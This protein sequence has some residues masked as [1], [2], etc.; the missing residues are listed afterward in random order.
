VHLLLVAIEIDVVS[1]RPLGHT[2]AHARIWC[3]ALKQRLLTA[4]MSIGKKNEC[5]G[6]PE[7]IYLL[8]QFH[9]LGQTL[10]MPIVRS[11]KKKTDI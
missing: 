11:T 4:H 10:K 1:M 8:V 5:T 7:E 3:V 9:F 2:V 6:M